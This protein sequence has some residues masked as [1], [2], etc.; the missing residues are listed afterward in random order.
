MDI[1]IDKAR[2]VF[3][4]RGVFY[5][6]ALFDGREVVAYAGETEKDARASLK[7]HLIEIRDEINAQL[8]RGI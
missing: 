5:A 7:T 6:T 4:R 2:G 8:E 1:R 3:N